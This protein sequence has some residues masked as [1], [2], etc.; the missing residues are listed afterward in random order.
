MISLEIRADSDK[1]GI[2]ETSLEGTDVSAVAHLDDEIP[3]E[4]CGKDLAEY[5]GW[6]HD[7]TGNRWCENITDAEASERLIKADVYGSDVPTEAEPGK[8]LPG[9]WI[10][11]STDLEEESV[12]VQISIGD[13]RGCVE[14]VLRR[15]I[16]PETGKRSLLLHMPDPEGAEQHVPMTKLHTNTYR[17]G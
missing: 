17:I 1:Y 7:S 6:V 2:E 15:W 12:K 10:G 9:N 14:M 3:C 13:P 4:N 5:D 16:D 8:N 11:F